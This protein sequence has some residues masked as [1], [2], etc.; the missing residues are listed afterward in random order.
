MWDT[1]KGERVGV[2]AGHENRVSCLGVSQDGMALCTGSWDSMLKVGRLIISRRLSNNTDLAIFIT[3]RFGHNQFGVF[4][5]SS[6]F[7]CVGSCH[8]NFWLSN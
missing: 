1:L 4:F 7:W 6:Q 5:D 3:H 8:S 2:L